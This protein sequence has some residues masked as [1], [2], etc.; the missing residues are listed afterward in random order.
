MGEVYNPVIGFSPQSGSSCSP[1]P[2]GVMV[3]IKRLQQTGAGC[4][5]ANGAVLSLGGAQAQVAAHTLLGWV[6]VGEK[7]I[8]CLARVWQLL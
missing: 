6:M 7:N 2:L 4:W 8:S 5:G 3:S 1:L